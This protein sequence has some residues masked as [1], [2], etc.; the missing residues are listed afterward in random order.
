MIGNFMGCTL[1]VFIWIM[2]L[3]LFCTGI[4]SLMKFLYEHCN[5]SPLGGVII[6]AFVIS[7]VM[8]LALAIAMPLG[9]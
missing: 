5:Y 3:L 4:T 7:M 2:I 1:V 8:G 6:A 9:L